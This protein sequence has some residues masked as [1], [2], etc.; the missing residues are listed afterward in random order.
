MALIIEAAEVKD[1]P[2]IRALLAEGDL[3]ADDVADHLTA[4]LV[5]RQG[6]ALVG[7][8]GMEIM[9]PIGLLRSLAVTAGSRSRG[10]G[11]ALIGDLLARARQ[12]GLRE[13][14]LLTTTAADYFA[15]RGWTPIDRADAP[16]A[17]R[18]TLQFQGLCPGSAR[19]MKLT[20]T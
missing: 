7:T 17:I 4:F 15:R 3:P 10:A 6:S 19:C 13:A 16:D 14:Y 11:A 1:L 20:L 12:R 9:P 5:A 2:A 18:A 8:I